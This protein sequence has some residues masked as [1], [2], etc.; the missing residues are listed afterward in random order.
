MLVAALVAVSLTLQGSSLVGS[1]DPSSSLR[2]L[3]V[4]LAFV[5]DRQFRFDRLDK[6]RRDLELAA[7]PALELLARSASSDPSGSV[8]FLPH[9]ANFA[10]L[11]DRPW[12]PAPLFQRYVSYTP[13]LDSLNARFYA[14]PSGAT[15]LVSRT[16][17]AIDFR[18]PLFESPRTLMSIFC[19]YRKI[20]QLDG[21]VLS[22]RDAELS[23]V[24]SVALLPGR[25]CVVLKVLP[26]QR[27]PLLVRMAE[28]LW[29]PEHPR[30]QTNESEY[31]R[32]TE[33]VDGVEVVVGGSVPGLAIGGVA[34]PHVE[35]GNRFLCVSG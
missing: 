21:F 2:A 14:S 18:S 6:S 25:T 34:L 23:C 19:H 1:V 10:S 22:R 24:T 7:K 11:V 33:A 15:F 5:G 35:N 31:V 3:A 4:D 27:T 32:A 13:M 30:V 17:A 16:D 28:T 20:D 12:S 29:R 9:D 8:D 26:L